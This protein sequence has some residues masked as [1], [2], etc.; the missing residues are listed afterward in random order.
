MDG[1]PDDLIPCSA[2][3]LGEGLVTLHVIAFGIFVKDRNGH[4][5][6]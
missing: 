5:V 6:D 4:G 3:E 1:M 2:D